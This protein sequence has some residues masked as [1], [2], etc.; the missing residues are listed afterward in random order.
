MWQS[1]CLYVGYYNNY[2]AAYII[3]LS[4]ALCA[5]AVVVVVVQCSV[6]AG[7]DAGAIKE[8]LETQI[9]LG[10]PFLLSISASSL[11]VLV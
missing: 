11:F 5:G 7:L 6:M 8:I 4:H 1:V 3:M 10:R 2:I 9:L